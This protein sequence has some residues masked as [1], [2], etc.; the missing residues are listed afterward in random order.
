MRVPLSWLAEFIDDLPP[1]EQ[2]VERLTMAGLEVE[3]VDLPD[4]RLVSGLV[5][6]RILEKVQHPNADRLSLCQVEDGDGA[7]QVVCGATNMSTGDMVVLARPKTVLPGGLKIKKSKI[8]GEA[9]A[10]MLC[11]ASELGVSADHSGIIVLDSA[12]APGLPAA[13]LLGLDQTVIELGITPNRGDCL[14]IRGVA[15]EVAALCGCALSAGYSA[16]LDPPEGQSEFAVAIDDVELC[17]MYRGLA[18]TGIKVAPSPAWL[19][20]RLIAAGLRPI[21]NIVDVTN[22]I[23]LEYGQPLHAFDSEL[24]NGRTISVRTVDGPTTIETLDEEERSLVAGDLVIC[25]KTGPVAVA[26]VMGGARTAVHDATSE[27]FLESALFEPRAVRVTSRRLGLISDS[28][29]RFERGIDPSGVE[30]ALLRAAALI[31]EVAGGSIA[32]GIAKAGE[33]PAAAAPVLVRTARIEKLLGRAVARDDAHKHFAALGADVTLEGDDLN[34]VAPSHRHDLTRE[35]DWI[36]EIARLEGYDS[37]EPVPPSVPMHTAVVPPVHSFQRD[38]R[39]RLATDG[40]NEAVSLSFCSST[41]NASFRGL[42]ADSSVSVALRNPLR[43]DEAE[44]RRSL[45]PGVLTAHVSNARSGRDVT[46]FFSI[47]RTFS[48]NAGG[49]VSEID[50]IAGVLS[51]PRRA[52]GPGSAGEVT[53]WDAKGVVERLVRLVAP[54]AVVAWE[55]TAACP[56]LHP[57]EAAR[58]RLGDVVVGVVGRLHPDVADRLEV[59]GDACVFEVDSRLVLEYAPPRSALK[60]VPRY[61]ASSRDISFLVPNDLLAGTVVAAVESMNEPLIEHVGVFDEYV[62]KGVPDGHRALAFSIVYRSADGTLTDD[63]VAELHDGVVKRLT[64]GL[65]IHVRT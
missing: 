38:A 44:M 65:G 46:D 17:S 62:G 14:S 27:I 3:D 12:V 56:Y 22:Y 21:N 63:A 49:V 8:R 60:P 41:L 47:G 28:S 29:Y 20:T 61:P 31:A 13:E 2:L 42:H 55:P 5:T 36:E 53:F 59:R 23:L 45:I 18:V 15:R 48:A 52:R 37:F 9:S 6:A 10:G 25:D 40:M 51:G 24:L 4:E 64:D 34:L 43:S 16:V 7:R 19:A 32:G 1:L 57:R 50:A 11:S 58:I 30:K 54:Q 33:I 26:G 39:L 35:V